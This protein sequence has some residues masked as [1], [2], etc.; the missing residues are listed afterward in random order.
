MKAA[1]RTHG[2]S[3]GAGATPWS[4][5]ARRRRLLFDGNNCADACGLKVDREMKKRIPRTEP[6]VPWRQP[7]LVR[8]KSANLGFEDVRITHKMKSASRYVQSDKWTGNQRNQSKRA[9]QIGKVAG[10]K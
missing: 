6:A 4:G 7:L 8:K 9:P 1:Q 3:S 5:K 10:L 2:E